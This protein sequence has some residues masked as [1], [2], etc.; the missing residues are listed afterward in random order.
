MTLP[1]TSVSVDAHTSCC[2]VCDRK[3][4]ARGLCKRC[5]RIAKDTGWLL[6]FERSTMDADSVLDDWMILRSEGYTIPQA[7]RRLG[8]TTDAFRLHLKRGQAGKDER[9][10]SHP[11]GW[12]AR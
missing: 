2:L 1:R 11:Y 8:I 12:N 10:K 9:A 4:A 7:A 3:A 5:Y 6:D